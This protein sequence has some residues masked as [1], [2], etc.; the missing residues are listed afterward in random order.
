MLDL[1]PVTFSLTSVTIQVVEARTSKMATV[2]KLA[3]LQKIKKEKGLL[4]GSFSNKLT[5]QQ[6]CEKWKEVTAL[7]S[8]TL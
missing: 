2:Y 8:H 4:F 7:P 6:K 5:R 1:S 3:V